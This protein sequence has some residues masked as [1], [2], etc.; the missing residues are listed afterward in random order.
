ML[1]HAKTIVV[2]YCDRGL[3][4]LP[5]WLK[6]LSIARTAWPGV[7]IDTGPILCGLH[8]CLQASASALV[9]VFIL[10]ND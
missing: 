7:A 8:G 10:S 2:A 6:L 3:L 9:F 4:E 1:L 5:Q